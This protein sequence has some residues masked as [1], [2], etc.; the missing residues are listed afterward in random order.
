M[1]IMLSQKE[2]TS[3]KFS[4]AK[5]LLIWYRCGPGYYAGVDITVRG[6][7][8]DAVVRCASTR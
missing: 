4:W 2:I 3:I 1:C 8:P 6:S 5:Y 7:W